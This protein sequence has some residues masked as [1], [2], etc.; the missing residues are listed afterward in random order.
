MKP[1]MNGIALG[2]LGAV[3]TV[4]ATKLSSKLGVQ[5]A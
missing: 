3:V 2:V 1:I 5:S 4:V